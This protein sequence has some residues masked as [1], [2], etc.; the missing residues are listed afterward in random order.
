LASRLTGWRIDIHSQSKI[1]EMERR[2]RAEIAAIP[3]VG[4]E[5]AVQLFDLGWRSLRDLA[6]ANTDELAQVV[7]VD[8]AERII[9]LANDA[10]S[11]NLQL[12]VVYEE[13]AELQ[14]EG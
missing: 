4:H 11:G 1:R 7:G 10:A 9:D 3:G 2:S 6:V 14:G 13:E 12:E 5:L 8:E